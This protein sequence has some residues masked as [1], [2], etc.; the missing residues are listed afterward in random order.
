MYGHQL[1]ALFER[2]HAAGL[3]ESRKQFSLEWC[4]RGE[5][6]LR[7]YERREGATARVSATTIM[8]VRARLA[9]VVRL[10]PELAT[11]VREIEAAIERDQYVAGLLGRRSVAGISHGTCSIVR[12]LDR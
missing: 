2:I 9:E 1:V 4:G 6:L 11:E 10:M 7:D 5:D 3:S 8:R 12:N